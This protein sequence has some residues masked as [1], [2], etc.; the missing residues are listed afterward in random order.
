[1]ALKIYSYKGCSTCKNALNYLDKQGLKHTVIDIVENPPKKTELKA[2]LGVYEGNVK[3]LFNTSGQVYRDMDLT[4]K[5]ADMS[6]EEALD[7]LS[8][9]GK[10]V[11]RPFLMGGSEALAVGFKEVEWKKVLK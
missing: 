10:L 9:H 4:D 5:L 6:I 8:K 11:K 1:L 3:K 7:L 2:M